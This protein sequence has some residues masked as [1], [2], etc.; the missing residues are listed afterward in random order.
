MKQIVEKLLTY[1]AMDT[2]VV[3]K[4]GET[5]LDTAERN[6]MSLV[7]YILSNHGVLNAKAPEATEVP[8]NS[9]NRSK[10]KD[11]KQTVT[12]IRHTVHNQLQ[13]TRQTRRR[14]QGMAKRLEKMHLE[15]LNNAINSTT[16]VAVLIATVAFAAIF[17]VPGKY[18]DDPSN[19]APDMSVGEAMVGTRSEFVVFFVFDSFAL[20]LSLGVVV[21]QTSVVVTE[22]RAKKKLMAVINKLMWLACVMVSVAFLAL[23]Y[24]VVGHHDRVLAVGVTLI[25]TVIMATTLGTMCCWVVLNKVQSFKLRK[26]SAASNASPSRPNSMMSDSDKALDNDV[27]KTVYAI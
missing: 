16:V 27:Y 17:S 19:M 11:F 5:A 26:R 18:A 12:V 20:F 8:P 4:Q 14:V 21:V 23:S 10:S 6:A 22:R 25:G 7:S 24:I 15:G 3:N 9:T 1:E 13:H 2:S